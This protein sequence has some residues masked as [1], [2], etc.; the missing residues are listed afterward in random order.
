M[1]DISEI[2]TANFDVDETQAALVT[3]ILVDAGRR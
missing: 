3:A 2:G 1:T